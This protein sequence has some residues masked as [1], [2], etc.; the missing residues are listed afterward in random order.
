MR[1]KNSLALIAISAAILLPGC[2]GL[3]VWQNGRH[4]QT[5]LS[6][7]YAADSVDKVA[8]YVFS[9][10]EAVNGQDIPMDALDIVGSILMLPIKLLSGDFSF[11]G[12]QIGL[13]QSH[14][15]YKVERGVTFEPDSRNAGPSLELAN[16]VKEHLSDKGYPATVITTMP[17]TGEIPLADVLAHARNEGYD[18]AFVVYYKGLSSWTEYA[19][20]ETHY[21]GRTR[22]V[23]TNVNVFNGFLFIPNAGMFDVNTGEQLWKYNN[24]GMVQKA[25]LPNLAGEPFVAVVSEALVRNGGDDYFI[26]AKK[27][28]TLLFDPEHWQKSFI[29]IPQKGDGKRR[30]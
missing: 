27:A 21:S 8:V 4:F 5:S 2:G 17:H 15:P 22:I 12:T 25:H 24:Y 7:K 23:T 10:G 16:A 18:V 6:P 1:Y 20:T 30:M 29:E 11:G 14:F 28:A 26:A 3:K 19:G 13:H 9:E